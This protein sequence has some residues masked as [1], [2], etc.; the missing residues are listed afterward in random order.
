META[1]TRLPRLR[2]TVGPDLESHLG[3]W[4]RRV[5]NH[6]SGAFARA[7]QTKHISVAEWVLMCHVQG[8]PGITPGELAELLDLTRG[9][10]SK[11]IDKLEAKRWIARSKK[12]QDGR[13]QLLSLT[14]LGGRILPELAEIADQNDRQF[15]EGLDPGERATLRRLLSKLTEIH[16]IRDVP[17][18]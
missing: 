14:P 15:F 4:L 8:C 11:I 3:Y 6:V 7:L 12:P 13:V 9:A 17:I 2:S 1:S 10:V 18:E 16:Q 5:S